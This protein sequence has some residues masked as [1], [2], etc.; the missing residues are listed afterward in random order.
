[1]TC[2]RT[3]TNATLALKGYNTKYKKRKNYRHMATLSMG[4][5]HQQWG[6]RALLHSTHGRKR[7]P[8]SHALTKGVPATCEHQDAVSNTV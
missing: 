1:M 5:S 8:L 2:F 4:T 3:L 6:L 7:R